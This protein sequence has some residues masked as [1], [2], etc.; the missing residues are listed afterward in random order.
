MVC[1]EICTTEPPPRVLQAPRT[2]AYCSQ[3]FLKYTPTSPKR[4]DYITKPRSIPRVLLG[5]SLTKLYSGAKYPR[6]MLPGEGLL[7]FIEQQQKWAGRK[8]RNPGQGNQRMSTGLCHSGKMC[9]GCSPAKTATGIILSLG[10]YSE[11]T[12]IAELE[13]CQGWEIRW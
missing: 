5:E 12:V 6:S 4:C 7:G 10:S 8:P 9:D 1:P 11:S 13:S 3:K 2:P